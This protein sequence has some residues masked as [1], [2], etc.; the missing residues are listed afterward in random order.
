M[1]CLSIRPPQPAAPRRSSLLPDGGID[2]QFQIWN[3][4]QPRHRLDKSLL[5]DTL[6]VKH[7]LIRPD[8]RNDVSETAI[9]RSHCHEEFA[10]DMFGIHYVK[11]S[12]TQFALHYHNGRLRH[13]GAGVA[14]LCYAPASVIALVPIGSQR[15]PFIFNEITVDYQPV[16]VQGELIYRVIDPPK[17]ASLFDFTVVIPS[18][19]YLSDDR[20]QL[21]QRL[22]YLTQALARA[23]MQSRPLRQA[24]QASDDIAA[25]VQAGLSGQ[26]EL[27]ALG[28]EVL[29][30]SIH[31]IK[32]TPEMARALEAEAREELLRNAD[33]A[34]YV[35]RNA[36]VEQER[37]IKE[38][39]LNTEIAV[40]G[41]K[42]QIRETKLAADLAAEEKEQQIRESKLQGQ[43]KLEEERRRLVAARAD[44]ARAEADAQGYAVEAALKPLRELDGDL[45]QALAVQSADPRRMVSL[46]LK[47]IAQNAGKI[48]QLNISPDLLESLLSKGNTDDD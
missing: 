32:P 13:S 35:R 7:T 36:A 8:A 15:A 10:K 33:E 37:R 29:S 16:T 31:A 17:V 22:I 28:V 41:K 3:C 46:A 18:H 6:S 2:S 19:R 1:Y 43:V 34:V 38:N 12:P 42:R 40:E 21:P 4:C 9:R 14:F 11:T 5:V 23:T 47:E 39:E 24:I 20:E 25:A 30:V 45:L 48:G 27:A 26:K 44:N